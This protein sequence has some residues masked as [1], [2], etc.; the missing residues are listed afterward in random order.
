M[1]SN[2]GKFASSTE[3]SM[4]GSTPLS[5]LSWVKHYTYNFK[6]KKLI[7]SRTAQLKNM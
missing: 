3:H 5:W 6:K 4:Y 1:T 7:L 2:E